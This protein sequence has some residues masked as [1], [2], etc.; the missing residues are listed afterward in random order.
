[1]LNWIAAPLGTKEWEL[2]EYGVE[3]KHFTRAADGSPV[4]NEL[5]RKELGSQ[6]NFLVG[7]VPV[8]VRTADVPNYVT[9]LINYGNQTVKYLDKEL[10]A[11]I[12]LELPANYSKV[13]K[14]T[15]DKILDILRGR[16]PVS[17][18]DQVVKEWR[19][20]GGDEGRAF[21]EKT[22]ADNGR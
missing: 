13:L 12:K 9:D 5:G 11:G 7:R 15:E 2:R 22:L 3:G 18:L 21:L 19:S 17:D 1:V 16:R 4:P 10:T 6:Y 14:P 8:Q 20:S